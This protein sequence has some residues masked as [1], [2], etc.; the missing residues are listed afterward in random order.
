M[1]IKVDIQKRNLNYEHA[2]CG[3]KTGRCRAQTVERR[4]DILVFP[5][6][7]KHCDDEQDYNYARGDNAERCG[8]R[9]RNA[10]VT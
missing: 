5:K 2:R 1:L 6:A 9:A 3:D 10:A 4:F 8:D 7:V